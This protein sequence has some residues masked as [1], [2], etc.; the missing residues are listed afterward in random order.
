MEAFELREGQGFAIG[1]GEEG[2]KRRDV[3]RELLL[4]GILLI[5]WG[6]CPVQ[7]WVFRR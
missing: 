4:D 2:N 1:R 7:G 6:A 5:E 3:G